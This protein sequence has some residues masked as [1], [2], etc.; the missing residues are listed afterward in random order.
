MEKVK[1]ECG[2]VNPYGTVICESCGKPFFEEG[3]ELLDMR[4][5]GVAR[6]SQSYNKTII[7]KIWNFF[8]SVK[9]G[10]WIIVITL[11]ASSIGTI[12][13]QEFYIPP[14]SN[15]SLF[16]QD[17]YGTLG[18]LYYSFGF[19]NLYSSWW[20]MLLIASL[21]VSLIICS[22]DRVVPLHRALKTQRVTRHE[23]FLQRQ[24]VHGVSK[25]DNQAETIDQAK[26]LLK[27][28]KYEIFE[29]EGNIVA[30]K[31]RFSRWGPYV[32][33]IGLI[34]F[35]IG[36]MLRFFPGMYVDDN[37]WVRE[38]ETVV[39]RGTDGEFF[40][41][42]DKFT[43]DFYDDADARFQDA[44]VRAGSPVVKTYQ[45]SATLFKRVDDGVV[46]REPELVEVAR[47][48]IRVNDPFKF[49]S[50]ALYQYAFK[51]NEISQMSFE[52]EELKTGERLGRIDVSTYDPSSIY[53]L[54]NGYL[55]EIIEY[56][57]DFHFDDN[58]TP[59]SRSRIP[60]NPA[61]IFKMITPENEAGEI[62]FVGIQTNQD[63]NGENTHR[64][65]FVD[66]DMNHVTNLVVRKDHTLGILIVGGI[67]FMIGLT[68][69]MYWTHRRIWIQKIND[70]LWVSAHTNK[71]WYGLK[72]DI[73][74]IVT[75]TQL[76]MPVDK[77]E[78]E[79]K[80]M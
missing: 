4:Y 42:N 34:V 61:F 13:P 7:D 17:E 29:E 38:G 32:N 46:G 69:G 36:C 33:H 73:E 62:S 51:Q 20:Y 15:P 11:L 5:E 68:Q 45:T 21:G 65:R 66:I 35:L 37:I 14:G 25:V 47:H 78:E 43:V 63:I 80:K 8:S 56:F 48:D 57:P 49:N 31:G 75:S 70:E 2:H 10:I 3:K 67:I 50:F 64:M 27:S 1:C 28:K 19:H 40:L 6:R 72:K 16:Y 55:I 18:K 59:A 53:D 9:V 58:R 60:N 76:T 39:V 26:Q 74:T 54:G 41:R 44:L 23:G 52:L 12:F 77:V 71:N 79:E 30:E 24:R 22:L